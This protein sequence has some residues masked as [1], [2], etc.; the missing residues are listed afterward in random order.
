MT[1]ADDKRFADEWFADEA[2]WMATYPFMFPEKRIAAADSD[3]EQILALAQRE[4][5]NVLDLACG[6]GRHS[7]SLAQRG[8]TVTGV[9]RSPFLLG[10]ARAR[11]A[12]LNA[13]VEWVQADMRA[14]SR[15]AAFDL[16]LSLFTSLGYFAD[17]ADNQRV[18]NNVAASLRPGGVFVLDMMGKEALARV[19][20]PTTSREIP[21][22]LVIHRHK[23]IADWSQLENEWILIEGESSRTFRFRHWIYSGREIERMFREAGFTNV[24]LFGNYL[25]APYGN[26]A[27][28][29]VAVGRIG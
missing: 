18:L 25:G 16:A 4:N 11:A 27:S 24:R 2:F 3:V 26:E 5:G 19:F 17:D 7:V 21:N 8:F 9:D 12:E 13:H 23:V 1:H 6:P 15:P 10:K 29:L 28:R 22:G 14:F 20:S